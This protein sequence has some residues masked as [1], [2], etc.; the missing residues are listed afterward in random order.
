[1]TTY[2][3]VYDTESGEASYEGDE[4]QSWQSFIAAATK[5]AIAMGLVAEGDS[6]LDHENEIYKD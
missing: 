2:T 5:S 1:M 3:I 6:V 4:G